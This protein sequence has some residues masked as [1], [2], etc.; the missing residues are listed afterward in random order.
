MAK[1]SVIAAAVEARSYWLAVVAMVFAVV[2]AFA[3]L[4]LVVAMYFRDVDDET[5]TEVE[6]APPAIGL[7]AGA[8]IVAAVLFTV[9]M[10][11]VPGVLESLSSTA[12]GL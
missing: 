4:R 1:F 8:V 10:G 12:A 5:D 6:A 7:G 2:A 3:Y 11:V 9:A